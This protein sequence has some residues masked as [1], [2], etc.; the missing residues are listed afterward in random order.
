MN[1]TA[2]I[3][4]ALAAGLIITAIGAGCAGFGNSNTPAA[5][6]ATSTATPYVDPGQVFISTIRSN[7]PELSGHTD[8]ELMDAADYACANMNRNGSAIKAVDDFISTGHSRHAAVFIVGAGGTA[9]CS[10][11][12][13]YALQ[14][15]G[16]G[17]A[18]I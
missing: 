18:A 17:H 7:V 8:Q 15:D 10:A 3:I 16:A 14:S 5:G 11:T 13:D 2:R 12:L 4:A 6:P 9:Y 1:R